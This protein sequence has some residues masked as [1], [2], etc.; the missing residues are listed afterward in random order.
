MELPE[1]ASAGVGTRR[2]RHMMLLLWFSFLWACAEV[3]D[4]ETRKSQQIEKS[5]P[6]FDS[7]SHGHFS[8]M[9]EI[10]FYS[11]ILNQITSFDF[12]L[13][14]LSYGFLFAGITNGPDVWLSPGLV[15]IARPG[16][17]QAQTFYSEY[18]P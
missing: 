15:S 18:N 3:E 5:T 4:E 6:I 8:L 14:V 17:L 7:D 11:L 12:C 10:L 13:Y 9:N 1:G 16:L 2:Q